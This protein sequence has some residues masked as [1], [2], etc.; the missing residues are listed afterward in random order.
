MRISVSGVLLVMVLALLSVTACTKKTK[1]DKI[2]GVIE[3]VQKAAEDRDVKE[4]LAHIDRNY[5]DADGNDYQAVKGMLIYYF[6]RHQ[7]V[8][9]IVTNL[10]I[11]VDGS[12]ASAGFQAILSGRT[13]VSGDILPEALGAYRFEVSFRKD[14]NDWKIRFAR[15]ERWGEAGQ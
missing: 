3:A 1:E 7:K 4:V 9:V 14:K 2:R 5:R 13:G 8:G 10:T 11:A 12:S 15:W 6:F